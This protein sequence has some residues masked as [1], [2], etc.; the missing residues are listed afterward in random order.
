MS[1]PHSNITIGQQVSSLKEQ[2]I[3][4]QSA[5][6]DTEA[7]EIGTGERLAKVE[8]QLAA[9]LAACQ[10]KDSALE[11]ITV[12]PP[13]LVTTSHDMRRIAQSALA[14]Q[15]DNQALEHF[16][17]KVREQCQMTCL[18]KHAN[19]NWKYDTR[20]ECAEAIS[21]IKELP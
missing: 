1:N 15:L 18:E 21:S 19:G 14:S 17:A 12:V 3:S 8:Q 5:L 4:C 16:A 13:G 11:N 20:E 6:A 7:L 2:L 9:A 10:L